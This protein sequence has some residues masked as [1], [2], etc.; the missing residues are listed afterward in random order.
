MNIGMKKRL[1]AI[2]KADHEKKYKI[3]LAIAKEEKRKQ[4]KIDRAAR[5]KLAYIN[6]VA[7]FKFL[8]KGRGRQVKKI[9]LDNQKVEKFAREKDIKK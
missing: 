6:G 5:G 4:D 9:E 3:E 1:D 8:S 7:P 2:N